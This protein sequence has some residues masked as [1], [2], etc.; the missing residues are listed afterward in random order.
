MLVTTTI[1]HTTAV[2]RPHGEIDAATLPDLD[3]AARALP[4]SVT[5]LVWDLD[6][7]RF[8]DVAGLHLLARQRNA[9]RETGRTLSVIGL[10]RQPRRLLLLAQ[11]LFPA[12]RWEDFLP[13]GPPEAAA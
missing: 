8:M 4:T 5:H 13:D 1:D 3:A 10:A 2:I 6:H 11:H 9:C 7:A 12:G